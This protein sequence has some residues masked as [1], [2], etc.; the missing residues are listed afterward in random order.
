MPVANVRGARRVVVIDNKLLGRYTSGHGIFE[1][2]IKQQS[3]V[4]L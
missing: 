3:V 1:V 2:S 4:L